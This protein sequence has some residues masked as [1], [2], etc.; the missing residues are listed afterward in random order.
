MVASMLDEL[1]AP[2][3]L[4]RLRLT[5]RLAVAPMTRISATPE[6]LATDG[7]A[8]YYARFARGGFGLVI[9]EGIYPDQVY[10]QGYAGQPGLS[11]AEQARAWQLVVAAVHGHGGLI[12]AQLMHAGALSQFNRFRGETIGPSPIRP[13]GRQLALYGGTGPFP[14]PRP[15][16]E[17]DIAEAIEGFAAAARRARDLAGFDGIEIHGANGYLLDQF[18]TSTTN[19]RAD[20]YG[21]STA[22]RAQLIVEVATAVRRAVGGDCPLGVRI[23]QAKVND[24]DHKWSNAEA[25]AAAIF[26]RLN[27]CELDYVHVTEL[28][29]WR[30]AFADADASLAALARRFAPKLPVVANGQLHD[31]VRARAMLTQGEA[32]VI[33]IGKGALATPDWPRRIR[34]DLPVTSFDPAMLAPLAHLR[35]AEVAAP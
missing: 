2:F 12:F 33:A 13:R 4:G 7:M 35:D 11:D 34:A 20:R 27:D 29:A 17:R 6:G 25:D 3:E 16:A 31:P 32:D 10:S 23:S 14:V 24:S 5:N 22:D 9:T 26:G 18:L 19:H 21:G 30:G 1:F 15:M 8:N 28:A